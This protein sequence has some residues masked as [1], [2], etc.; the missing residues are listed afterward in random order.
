MARTAAGPCFSAP[1][2]CFPS[3]VREPDS[4]DTPDQQAGGREPEKAPLQ[5]WAISPAPTPQI[6]SVGPSELMQSFLSV[7]LLKLGTVLRH[8]DGT[9]Y[10][11]VPGVHLD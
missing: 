8:I 1:F 9:S 2:A 3:L 4:G 7:T 5:E 6:S 10:S 11:D